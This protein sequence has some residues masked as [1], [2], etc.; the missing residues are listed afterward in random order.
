MKGPAGFDIPNRD[1]RIYGTGN[2]PLCWTPLTTIAQALTT[3]LLHPTRALNR[4]ILISPIRNLTQNILL[5]TLES[6]LDTK[7][8]TTNV[9]VAL[10]NKNALIA[11]EKGEV[12]KAMKGL[13][14]SNQFFEDEDGGVNFFDKAENELVGVQDVGVE[15]AVRMAIELYGLETPVTEGMYKVDP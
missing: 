15:E 2:N 11:L 1:A 7:F 9:D 5:T 14:I 6:I 10:M 4:S 8:T 3:M 12:V 13:T